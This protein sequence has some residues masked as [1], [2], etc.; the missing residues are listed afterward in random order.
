MRPESRSASYPLQAEKLSVRGASLPMRI[1]GWFFRGLASH[2]TALVLMALLLA[3]LALQ[4]VIPQR[5]TVSD[6]QYTLWRARHPAVT[7][8]M[9]ALGLDRI[10]STLWFWCIGAA[11]AAA[12]S[13]SVARRTWRLLR[14][15][16]APRGAELRQWSAGPQEA[17]PLGA[18]RLHSMGYA[19]KSDEAGL[20]A[21]KG[22][23]GPW[24]SLAFHAGLL[25][26]VA[27]AFISAGTRFA[28]YVELAPGQAFGPEDAY[29]QIR[30]G[31]MVQGRPDVAVQMKSIA[32]SFWP[33]GMVKDLQ[34]DVALRGRN[35]QEVAGTIGR[36]HS[37]AIG[38]VSLMAGSPLGPA[39][40]LEYHAPG[41]QNP[42]SGYINF[43]D[44][45]GRLVN[46]FTPPGSAAQVEVELVGDWRAALEGIGEASPPVL[47]LT[48]K[49]EK[50]APMILALRRGESV[51]LAGGELRF[52]ALQP[53][54]LFMVSRDA[55]IPVMVVG[56]ALGI[57]GLALA[58][59]VAPR[60][61]Q[62]RRQN[63]GWLVEGRA[64]WGRDSLTR[65]AAALLA[66]MGTTS[67]QAAV[68]PAG[69]GDGSNNSLSFPVATG[70]ERAR[71]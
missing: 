57:V 32:V 15:G 11:L 52:V 56:G 12:L 7:G 28:G 63:N 35:Q 60:W 19:V 43:S 47:R 67:Q 54:V 5:G 17:L 68:A 49:D 3:C 4:A 23:V 55:G 65:E 58:L 27:G 64:S 24:G 30:K 16:P 6:L 51:T 2:K 37:I 33:D 18:R 10:A 59:L 40:L 34:A 26:L 70:P 29:A 9:V 38:G 42:G 69:E 14:H 36:N 21:R 13:V 1:S 22:M 25:V 53:W 41:G 48:T 39:V 20:I 31:V 44:V 61:I 8:M 66:A 45:G 46:R 62:V 71:R 50:G